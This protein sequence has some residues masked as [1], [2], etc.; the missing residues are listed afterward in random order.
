MRT[1]ARKL[2]DWSLLIFDSN[3]C[4]VCVCVCVQA[5]WTHVLSWC[6][7]C[8]KYKLLI[9]SHAF[10][11]MVRIPAAWTGGVRLPAERA[12]AVKLMCTFPDAP[13]LAVRLAA[14]GARR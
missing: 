12:A 9:V 13:R 1:R 6:S 2:D 5:V 7:A 14:R 11:R 4:G 3:V 10:L 8:V